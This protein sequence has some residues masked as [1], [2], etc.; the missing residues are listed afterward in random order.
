[1]CGMINGER[2]WSFG[3]NR[4]M[5]LYIHS[6]PRLETGE[7]CWLLS[8]PFFPT[9]NKFTKFGQVDLLKVSW[10]CLFLLICTASD[11]LWALKLL[12]HLLW[13]NPKYIHFPHCSQSEPFKT[14]LGLHYNSPLKLSLAPYFF[15]RTFP[16]TML[17][18]IIGVQKYWSL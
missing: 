10:T 7:L 11:P 2:S 16:T 18:W 6:A 4:C 5:Y 13:S 1:M 8:L 15:L 17:D 12:P 14:E 3:Q 9:C